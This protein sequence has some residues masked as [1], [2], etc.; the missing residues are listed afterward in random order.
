MQPT[1]MLRTG[2]DLGTGAR[3]ANRQQLTHQ[4]DWMTWDSSPSQPMLARILTMVEL[5]LRMRPL[6][7][8]ARCA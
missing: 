6:E 1:Q 8:M 2:P 3:L 5:T 4:E 7:R